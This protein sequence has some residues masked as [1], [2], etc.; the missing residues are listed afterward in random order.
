ML[1]LNFFQ[2]L[3][4]EVSLVLLVLRVHRVHRVHRA[5]TLERFPTMETSLETPSALRFSSIWPV[6]TSTPTHRSHTRSVFVVKLNL[7]SITWLST[8]NGA[9]TVKLDTRYYVQIWQMNFYFQVTVFAALSLDLL[10]LRD[11][12]ERRESV[13]SRVTYRPTHRVRATLRVT[14]EAA[15]G[16]QTLISADSLR[17]WTTQVLPWKSQIISRVSPLKLS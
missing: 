9:K 17:D 12:G 14:H 1:I 13:E 6:S 16:A 2:V 8:G 3:D 10:G 4:S 5:V 15:P 7:A 11:Q